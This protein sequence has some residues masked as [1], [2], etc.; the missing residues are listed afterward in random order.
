MYSTNELL[1][2]QKKIDSKNNLQETVDITKDQKKFIYSNDCK[3]QDNKSLP[4]IFNYVYILRY[5]QDERI[6]YN[7]YEVY[8]SILAYI[9]YI[10]GEN[11]SEHQ[12]QS[13][14]NYILQNTSDIMYVNYMVEYD[15]HNKEY[16]LNDSKSIQDSSIEYFDKLLL[17]CQVYNRKDI[18]I[19]IFNDIVSNESLYDII[20]I[21]EN[22]LDVY[23]Y[24]NHKW[25]DQYGSTLHIIKASMS[26]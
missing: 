3:N 2:K 22:L 14:F 10:N 15:R 26:I 1:E 8:I 17:L 7:K 5:T 13:V 20:K 24:F 23:N 11:I 16:M 4:S 9:F 18:F 12:I 6:L 19:K 21:S 25:R